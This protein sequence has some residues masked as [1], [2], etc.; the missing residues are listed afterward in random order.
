MTTYNQDLLITNDLAVLPQVRDLVASAVHKGGF[1][2]H[3]LNRLQIAVDE[4]VTNII[5]H[6]YDGRSRGSGHI[7]ISVSTNADEFRVSIIDQGTAFDPNTMGDIDIEE[8]TRQG[9]GGG[10]GVFLMRR[11][12]DVVDYHY[13]TGKRNRLMLVKYATPP[14]ATISGRHRAVR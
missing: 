11:I 9:R 4:A 2:D 8:H 12:M 13:E 1:P 7:Q 5:E 10:L 14:P 6:G 3:F